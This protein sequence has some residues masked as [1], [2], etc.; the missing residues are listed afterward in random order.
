VQQVTPES[1]NRLVASA[2]DDSSVIGIC[3]ETKL[4]NEE[5][6]WWTMIQACLSFCLMVA[7]LTYIQVY[8]YYIPHHLSKVI[9]NLFGLVS[10]LPECFSLYRIRTADKGR[11]IIISNR[12]IDEYA[13]GNVD[14][15][16]KK[17]SFPLGEDRFDTPPEPF[18]HV[19]D[20]IHSRCSRSYHSS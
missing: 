18:P 14:T 10:C 2:A 3:G 20:E 9:E 13:E 19:Q 5:G 15:P 12:I 8:E 16:H 7:R 17:N 4:A 11:P 6:S 1:L